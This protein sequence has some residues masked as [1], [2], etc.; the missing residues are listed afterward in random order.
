MIRRGHSGPVFLNEAV[1]S[2]PAQSIDDCYTVLQ[3]MQSGTSVL[4]GVQSGPVRCRQLSQLVQTCHNRLACRQL[5]VP[6]GALIST[7][8]GDLD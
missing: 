3:G 5:N 2:I 4:Q 7:L 8:R 6:V 1:L